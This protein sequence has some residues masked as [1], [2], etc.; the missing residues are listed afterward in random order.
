[1]LAHRS[2]KPLARLACGLCLLVC[3]VPLLT[4]GCGGRK[5][6]VDHVTVTGKVMYNKAPVPGGQVT[7]V[8]T[9]GFAS[10][11]R[12]DEQGNYSIESPVGDVKITVNN[13]MLRAGD[14]GMAMVKGGKAGAGDPRQKAEPIKGTYREIPGKYRTIETSDLTWTVTKD[15]T[16]HDIELK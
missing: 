13:S 1:M 9:D 4:S 11:G 3:L 8:N 7:F 6:S 12:I 10:E 16:T 2:F 5:R 15:Q 14:K